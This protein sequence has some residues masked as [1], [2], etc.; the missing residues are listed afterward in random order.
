M[1]DSAAF[2]RDEP[3]V[4]ADW[5]DYDPTSHAVTPA[6]KS[7]II[8]VDDLDGPR[9]AA[10][11]VRSYYDSSTAESGRFSLATTIFD[12]EWR[13]EREVVL[14]K[15]IRKEGPACFDIFEGEDVS[16]DTAR[17]QVQF[18]VVPLLIA[19]AGLVVG[20]PSIL[21][22]SL[23]S[24]SQDLATDPPVLVSTVLT[25]DLSTL[26]DPHTLTRLETAPEARWN[27]VSW[28]RSTLAPHLPERGMAL[29]G[30][31]S[32]NQSAS[33]D[34]FFLLTAERTVVRFVIAHDE[35][36]GAFT[37]RS[38]LSTFDAE[39]EVNLPFGDTLTHSLEVPPTGEMTY[40]KFGA[41]SVEALGDPV[42]R[43]SQLLPPFEKD[44]DLAIET[45]DET[46]RIL[47][48]PSCAVWNAT[49]AGGPAADAVDAAM[50]NTLEG[51]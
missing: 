1:L 45:V 35:S 46:P 41:T 36:A 6:A 7:Y 34:V 47:L 19:D 15:N 37:L 4:G 43:L 8:Q 10:F 30:K 42:P 27:R 38:A 48:S 39:S 25:A 31:I 21:V 3:A 22:R 33:G 32:A 40:F 20:N 26:P 16:C 13:P 14:G 24:A 11:R 9:F 44:W 23:E 17:W 51:T 50:P 5:Y 2:V 28:D 29:G 12:G 49:A 18:R